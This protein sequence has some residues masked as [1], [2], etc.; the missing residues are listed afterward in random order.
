MNG[1][2]LIYSQSRTEDLELFI[3]TEVTSKR[4]QTRIPVDGSML[5]LDVKAT[6]VP[7]N[8][9]QFLLFIKSSSL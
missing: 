5:P 9:Q 1:N 7:P 6:A 2:H 8:M 4:R 3:L